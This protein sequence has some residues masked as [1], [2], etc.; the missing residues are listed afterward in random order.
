VRIESVGDE[1]SNSPYVRPGIDK[2]QHRRAS[3]V[4]EVRCEALGREELLLTRDVSAGG[5]FVSAKEPFPMGSEVSLKLKLPTRDSLLSARGTVVYS[6]KGMGMGV[7]FA[8]IAEDLR[9]DLQ[10]F[11]DESL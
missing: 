11:V 10:K 1:E 4:T 5:L 6:L 8:D 7:Q 9:S 3:L 2:R